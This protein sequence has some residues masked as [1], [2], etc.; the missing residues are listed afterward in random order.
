MRII[1]I[2]LSCAKHCTKHFV[3]VHSLII[4]SKPCKVG[5]MFTCMSYMKLL[6]PS[7]HEKLKLVDFLRLRLIPTSIWL[8]SLQILLWLLHKGS[9]S[10]EKMRIIE[11]GPHGFAN[12]NEKSI[13]SGGWEEKGC[14]AGGKSWQETEEWMLNIGTPPL[15]LLGGWSWIVPSSGAPL[16][17]NTL[18]Y[19]ITLQ[20]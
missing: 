3:Y 16:G 4:L 5:P 6:S 14:S 10:L 11:K 12:G 9:F 13:K 2:D 15:N 7:T 8:Q 20:E 18:Y 1:I 17:Y 19:R